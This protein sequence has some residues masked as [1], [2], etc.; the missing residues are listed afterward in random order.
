MVGNSLL[1]YKKLEGKIASDKENKKLGRIIKIEEVREKSNQ[2]PKLFAFILV[3]NLL[4]KDVIILVEYE[5]IIKS[6]AEYVWF[7]I[8]KD[9]F[10]QEV[11]E[12]RLLMKMY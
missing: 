11:R 2:T 5:K 8:I 9:D 7:D 6:N 1:E 3:K 4:K 12:T 10:D